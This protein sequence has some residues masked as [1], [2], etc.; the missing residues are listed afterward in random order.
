MG[1]D[2]CFSVYKLNLQPF[3]FQRRGDVGAVHADGEGVVKVMSACP[4]LV[5][6]LHYDAF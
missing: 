1:G 3:L 4:E 2:S 6:V 5:G